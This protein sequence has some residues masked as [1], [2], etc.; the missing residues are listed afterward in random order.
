MKTVARDDDLRAQLH[1]LWNGVAAGWAEHAEFTDA[2]GAAVTERLLGLVSPEPGERVLDL[3]TGAGGMGL[4][5]AERVRPGGEVVLSDV[6]AEMVAVAAQRAEARGL[7]NVSARVLDLERIDEPDESYDVVFCREG[8]MLV[9]DPARAAGEIRRVLRPGGR[10]A[11]AV[12]GPRERNPWL[13]VVFAAATAELGVP[14]PPPGIPGPFS[15]D[16]PVRFAS[17]LAAAGL[18]DVHVEEVAVPYR[19]DSVDEWWARTTA[20]AGPLAQRLAVLPD[21]A[22]RALRERAQTEI[23]AYETAGG[24][25]V[26]GVALVATASG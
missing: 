20:L 7:G 10:A 2:R 9:P 4:A 19:A 1:R 5:A 26:P 14:V 6:A 15:L 11:L 24:L 23:R 13:D 25:D 17:L 21:P 12:W 8:I 3:A 18:A 22:A 16:D